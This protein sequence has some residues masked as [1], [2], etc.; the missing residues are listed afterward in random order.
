MSNIFLSAS[1]PTP[2]RGD[3]YASADPFL[4]QFAVRELLTVCL[5]RRRVIWGGHPAITPMVW[6]ICKDLSVNYAKAVKLYQSKIFEDEFPD[7]NAHFANVTYVEA[8]DG[9]LSKS[10]K[11]MRQQML[12][13]NFVAGVF[14]G[15]MEGIFAE[16]QLFAERHPNAKVVAVSSPGGAAMQLAQKLGQATDRIDFARLFFERLDVDAA[17]PRDQV[18]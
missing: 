6:S 5:G 1:V 17:E 12:Q 4:I 10:L 2:G 14:I 13:E 7:E 16:H 3:F 8:V 9:D 11:Q 18:E 15:G